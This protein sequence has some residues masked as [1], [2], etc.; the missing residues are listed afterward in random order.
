MD[1][2]LAQTI[3]NRRY[4]LLLRTTI[5]F[6][7]YQILAYPP[8]LYRTLAPY[9]LNIIRSS[10]LVACRFHTGRS[11][12]YFNQFHVNLYPTRAG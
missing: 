7:Y 11:P 10:C 8:V 3:K 9:S 5:S 12:I 1:K 2:G 6:K 4:I